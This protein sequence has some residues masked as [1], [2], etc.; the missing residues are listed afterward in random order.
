MAGVVLHKSLPITNLS[1]AQI[2]DVFSG[3]I[4]FWKDLGGNEAKI[5]V[6]TR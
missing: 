4:K 6:L 3:K 1:E 5:T 2:C